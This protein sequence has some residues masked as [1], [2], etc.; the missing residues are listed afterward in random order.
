MGLF[1]LMKTT[2]AER[3]RYNTV[4]NLIEDFVDEISGYI[5]NEADAE[6]L[7]QFAFSTPYEFEAGLVR[8][9]LKVKQDLNH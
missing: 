9:A 6:K 3:K 2:E 1:F 7:I 5:E 4:A 8:K